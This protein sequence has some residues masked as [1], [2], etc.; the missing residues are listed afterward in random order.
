MAGQ[1]VFGAAFGLVGVTVGVVPVF[2]L[3]ELRQGR[4]LGIVRLTSRMGPSQR[5]NAFGRR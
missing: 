1:A 2:A 5:N 3:A 4:Q